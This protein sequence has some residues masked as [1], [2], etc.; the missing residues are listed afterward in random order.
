[1]K[2]IVIIGANSFLSQSLLKLLS[3]NFNI[4]QVYNNNDNLID[5]SYDYLKITDFLE[6]KYEIDILY[7]ITSYINFSEKVSDIEKIFYT[8][9]ILLKKITDLYPNTK[10]VHTSS[11]AVYDFSLQP[12]SEF[13]K[14]HPKCSYGLS[15]LWGERIVQ[16]HKG[17]GV[18][19]RISS[20]FGESMKCNT[21]LPLIMKDAILENNI[22]L[23]GDGSR[24]QNYIYVEDAARI[25]YHAKDC[26]KDIPL[27]AVNNK[28]YS[29]LEIANIIKSIVPQL[30]ISYIDKDN[31]SNFIYN[32]NE[33]I[34][35]LNLT[36]ENNFNEQITNTFSWI[37][38]QS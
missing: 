1:M 35:Y 38:K 10:I 2:N 19:V 31:S 28:S 4:I 18:N 36:F 9:V 6:E 20:L 11:V 16:N 32:N 5:K 12:I 13:S 17:G 25:L 24:L 34:K 27:L 7:Y 37:R 33:T 30:Q 23:Y 29:N 8:N 14:L 26:K 15:K 3:N 22:S 21:F